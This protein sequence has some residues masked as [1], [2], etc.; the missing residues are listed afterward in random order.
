MHYV[1]P[2]TKELQHRP[3]ITKADTVMTKEKQ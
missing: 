3:F 2:T 1:Y